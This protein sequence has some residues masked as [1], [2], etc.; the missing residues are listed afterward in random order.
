M[1]RAT[2]NDRS[3]LLPLIA[4]ACL[5]VGA[6]ASSPR[7][8]TTVHESE[9]VYRGSD[10]VCREKVVTEQKRDRDNDRTRVATTETVC[11]DRR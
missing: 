6:C 2:P 8:H 9:R 7:T 3:R 11:R 4:M 1:N 5:G 10:E